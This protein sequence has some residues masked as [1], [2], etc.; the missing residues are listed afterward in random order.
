MAPFHQPAWQ[1]IRSRAFEEVQLLVR[2]QVI[3][4]AIDD[5][6]RGDSRVV[7]QIQFVCQHAA[8]RPLSVML[9]L[10]AV[11]LMRGGFGLPGAG[12]R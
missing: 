12:R 8:L 2:G 11:N 1:S 9:R 4:T 3:E 10:K 7:A 6:P 5:L